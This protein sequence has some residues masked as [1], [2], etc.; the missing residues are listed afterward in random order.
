[1]PNNVV[2]IAERREDFVAN[3]AA[4]TDENNLHAKP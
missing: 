3:G 1:M 2:W 4:G